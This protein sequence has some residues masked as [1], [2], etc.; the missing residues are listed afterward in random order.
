MNRDRRYH[1]SSSRD[2]SPPTYRRDP[3][4]H[5]NHLDLHQNN[6][7]RDLCTPK[8]SISR[9]EISSGG[10]RNRRLSDST[11]RRSSHD[12]ARS[13]NESNFNPSPSLR[14]YDSDAI[15]RLTVDDRFSAN[16][17]Y[18][19]HH[20]SEA[21]EHSKAHR[22]IRCISLAITSVTLLCLCL[23]GIETCIDAIRVTFTPFRDKVQD[24]TEQQQQQL[25]TIKED[26][27][28]RRMQ[29]K[30][31][32]A[33]I[34]SQDRGLLR[35]PGVISNHIDI[36]KS[37]R[38]VIDTQQTIETDDKINAMN[39]LG[40][41]LGSDATLDFFY[42]G[43]T[44]HHEEESDGPFNAYSYAI[45]PFSDDNSFAISVWIYLSSEAERGE[46]TIDSE[47]GKPPRVV[48]TTR[49]YQ[50]GEGCI[51]DLFGGSD[52]SSQA[53]TGMILYAQPN[54]SDENESGQTS[55]RMMLDYAVAS[56][57]RCR[58]LIGVNTALIREGEWH[59]S[60]I[61]LSL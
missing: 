6:S 44:A 21:D 24:N 5:G 46:R 58:T 28:K 32:L 53:A 45:L 4:N 1:Q 47:E 17:S 23:W 54:Y 12:K 36:T 14:R 49:T 25:F 51:S 39:Y 43:K 22:T 59:H 40:Q 7:S 9:R 41:N 18:R 37:K 52:S 38:A 50:S 48:L 34:E 13:S 56:E 33:K 29:I 16:D 2:L 60:K 8:G 19:Y 27:E 31:Q 35:G 11:W 26:K 3:N 15:D 57:M 61:V 10:L 20:G 55:Y 30:D 42:A